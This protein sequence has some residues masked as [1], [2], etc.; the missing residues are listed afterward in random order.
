MYYHTLANQQQTSSLN[1]LTEGGLPSLDNMSDE[2]QKTWLWFPLFSFFESGVQGG[3]IPNEFEWPM[4]FQDCRDAFNRTYVNLASAISNYNN[5]SSAA[6]NDATK[7]VLIEAR[8]G[9]HIRKDKSD[10]Q[11]SALKQRRKP[12]RK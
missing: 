4:T 3:K 10:T 11:N 7:P 9:M 12:K 2:A 5:Q 6:E 1:M 8:N